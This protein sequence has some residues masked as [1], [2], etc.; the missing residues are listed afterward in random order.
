MGLE[1]DPVST[2]MEGLHPASASVSREAESRARERTRIGVSEECCVIV[3]QVWHT[4]A[5]QLKRFFQPE[6][7][8]QI[9]LASLLVF[10]FAFRAGKGIE[11]TWAMAFVAAACTV[12]LLLFS[13]Q[14]GGVFPRTFWFGFLFLSWSAISF[15]LS[16]TKTYGL[17][18][19]LRDGAGFLLLCIGGAFAKNDAVV[20]RFLK[21]LLILVLVACAIGAFVYVLQPVSRFTGVFFHVL[22]TRDYW[23][24][25]WAEWLLLLW[26]VAV[27]SFWKNSPWIRGTLMGVVFG[28][29]LL[30]YS[31]GA[32][33]V[34]AAQL[35]LGAAFL[36]LCSKK[37]RALNTW[38]E[39]VL[40]AVVACVFFAGLNMVR[41]NFFPVESLTAKAT[42]TASEGT[43]TVDERRQFWAQALELSKE[44]PVF[45]WGPGSFRFV[46]PRLQEGVLATSDH[47]HNVFLK[48]AMERGWPA[49]ALF[50]LFMLSALL[51]FFAGAWKGDARS[52]AI[53]LGT[54]GL[55]AHN[56]IDY[57]MQFTLIIVPFW[58]LLGFGTASQGAKTW[59]AN[60]ASLLTW[61]RKEM[62]AGVWMQRSV[63]VVLTVA[64]LLLVIIE[65]RFLALERLAQ[66]VSSDHP[67]QAVEL[68]EQARHSL[69][70][71]DVHLEEVPLLVA[72]QQDQLAVEVLQDALRQNPLDGRLWV[73]LG[74]FS[75]MHRRYD[76]AHTAFARAYG[77]NAWNDLRPLYGL[78]EVTGRAGSQKELLELLPVAKNLLQAYAQAI[79]ANSHFI[80]LSWHVQEFASVTEL[81]SRIYPA[82]G[83]ALRRLNNEVQVISRTAKAVRER[84]RRGFLW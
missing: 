48:F 74:D 49:A 1:E 29:L 79:R 62:P 34:L 39:L 10:S 69:F 25:A 51:P 53:L 84:E 78:L 16:S 50:F 33:L 8:V 18:E 55:L 64:L 27:F 9:L 47:P 83:S 7:L 42:L 13:P 54:G 82:E 37:S 22:D 21:L 73:L 17:D 30:S 52:L 24:N 66:T 31:R 46:Q 72:L 44:R 77:L 15:L 40:T 56:M 71:R 6:I 11:S 67:E 32:V 28:C 41:G 35:I 61:N 4:G 68:Y 70:A 3:P 2:E 65:G 43:Q 76:D 60:M 14:R 75:M 81:M 38:G 5:V 57:N 80:A 12:L 45:G 36:I 58:I 20:K 26:P 19:L 59:F 23:P 63:Q